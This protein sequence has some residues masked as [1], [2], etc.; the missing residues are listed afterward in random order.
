MAFTMTRGCPRCATQNRVPAN[1]LADTGTCGACH[2]ELPPQAEPLEVDPGAFEEIVSTARVPVLV[3]FW[4]AWCGPCRAAAPEVHRVAQ[5]MA[6]RAI[7]LKVDTEAHPQLAARFGVQAIP[8]FAVLL[9]GRTV[10]QQAG[11]VPR[12]ELRRWLEQ[13]AGTA[14]HA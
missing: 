5:E 2:A 3:D 13:A 10:L 4:A 6:G 7:V 11:L 9:D 12:A 8:N 1:H 14:A